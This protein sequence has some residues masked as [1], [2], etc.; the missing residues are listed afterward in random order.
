[1]KAFLT[2][3]KASEEIEKSEQ[4]IADLKKFISLV[5]N[6]NA[7]TPEKLVIKYYAL[8]GRADK[9][10]IKINE[11]GYRIDGR[12][13]ISNDVTAI[14]Q[15]EITIDELHEMVKLIQKKNKA[16]VNKKWN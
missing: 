10:A 4:Y 7:D 14:I 5:E 16:I 9:V 13:Y 15:S 8:I 1:M 3:E 12:K 2:V 11:E 6:Y